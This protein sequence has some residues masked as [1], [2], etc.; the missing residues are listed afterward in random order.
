MTTTK[1]L[2]LAAILPFGFLLIAVVV[3]MRWRRRQADT[4][5]AAEAVR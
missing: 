4:T 5:V 3:F 1:V 2:A